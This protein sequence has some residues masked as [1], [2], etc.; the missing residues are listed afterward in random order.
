MTEAVQGPIQDRDLLKG[1]LRCTVSTAGIGYTLQPTLHWL[2]GLAGD[3]GN[4]RDGSGL[5]VGSREDFLLALPQSNTITNLL[6]IQPLS[7]NTPLAAAAYAGA[8]AVTGPNR[9][10]R[11]GLPM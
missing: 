1:I 4:S 6:V 2:L 5:R 7:I 9:A 8:A 10:S 11:S 3:A